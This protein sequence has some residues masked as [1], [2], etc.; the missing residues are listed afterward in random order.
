VSDFLRLIA[1]NDWAQKGQK[2]TSSPYYRVYE[3]KQK[4]LEQMNEQM[5]ALLAKHDV[6]PKHSTVLGLW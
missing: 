5:R 1:E 2:Q 6:D 4:A 3:S